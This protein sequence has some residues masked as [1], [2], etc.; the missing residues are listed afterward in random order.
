MLSRWPIRYKLFL[1]IALLLV[2]VGTLSASA[3][4]GVYAYRGLVKSLSLRSRELPLATDL[5]GQVSN[6]RATLSEVYAGRDVYREYAKLY[7]VGSLD[8][9]SESDSRGKETSPN[10]SRR[11]SFD[12]LA[13]WTKFD[14]QLGEFRDT[15]ARY[16][17]I[18]SD[19]TRIS[20][21]QIGRD[22]P[23]RN[24]LEK[25]KN[26]LSR[27]D[28]A[29]RAQVWLSDDF[30]NRELAGEVEQLADLVADLPS[31]L[32]ERLR[33]TSKEVAGKYRTAIF[34][35]W[36]S[37]LGALLISALF[38]RLFHRWV[39]SPLRVLVHGSRRVAQGDFKHR[40]HLEN[41]DEMFELAEAMNAM[42]ARFQE[43]RDDLD[44]QVQ[45]RTRQVVR[46]EQL[47]SVGFLAA[48]VAHE[49]NNPLASIA[50]C[51]ESLE[52]RV[53]SLLDS[54]SD[55]H[56]VI[57]DYLRMIQDEAF[58]CKQITEKL[59][60]FSRMGET[61]RQVVDLRELVESVIDMVSHLGKHRDKKIVLA[62]DS[63]VF[64]YVNSQEMKQV[65]INLIA[66]GLDSIERNG[67]VTVSVRAEEDRAQIDVQDNGCGMTEEV[68]EHLFEPFF[69]RRR[70]GEGIGLGLSITYRI[71]SDHD[72]RIEATSDGAGKGSRFVVTL[73][74]AKSQELQQKERDNR[75]QA[76]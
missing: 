74:L 61:D 13:L 59:L 37:T 5:S 46:S 76:A 27:V 75:Y 42:T 14:R 50:L 21:S 58:R 26:L 44:S 8:P 10:N 65:V 63:A 2:I 43:T 15:L 69:T 53:A 66:N 3:F 60:D 17:K 23:E 68:L 32:H 71:V 30:G 6:L 25:I 48:G 41:Q 9:L 47:A 54:E 52:S 45:T 57:R 73:P 70:Q 19:N 29:D 49:I 64:A 72:G 56:Q 1:G 11:G 24:T 4:Y 18:L 51:S 7:H 62:G 16:E 20:D 39:F 40:I 34:I 31:H 12:E 35:T 38:I 36:L 28:G 22:Y 55:D 67:S 33:A